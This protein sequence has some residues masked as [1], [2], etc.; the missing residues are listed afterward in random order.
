MYGY[1]CSLEPTPPPSPPCQHCVSKCQHLTDPPLPPSALTSYMH[2]PL[3]GMSSHGACS[4]MG[5]FVLGYVVLGHVV[6]WGMSSLGHI[7]SGHN[8]SGHSVNGACRLWGILS[9]GTVSWSIVSWGIVSWGM[10]SWGIMSEHQNF[11]QKS[12][13]KISLL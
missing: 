1:V 13:C 2:G 10:S 5:H 8:V 3:R 11:V 4:P 7:V 12:S 9:W 6:L